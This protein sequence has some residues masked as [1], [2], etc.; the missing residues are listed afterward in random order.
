[1]AIVEIKAATEVGYRS[2]LRGTPNAFLDR[3]YRNKYPDYSVQVAQVLEE[4][5]NTFGT[6]TGTVKCKLTAGPTVVF[7]KVCAN[8]KPFPWPTEKISDVLVASTY[9]ESASQPVSA[10][11]PYKINLGT[12]LVDP[13]VTRGG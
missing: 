4:N 6:F 12:K 9:L 3:Q 2:V 8:N 7:D 5:Q 13:Q 1:M 10:D 11:G